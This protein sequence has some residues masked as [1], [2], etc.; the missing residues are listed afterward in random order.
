M[1]VVHSHAE[2]FFNKRHIKA[3]SVIG[4]DNFK[5]FNV[6][7]KVIKVL[8]IDI[9]MHRLT[10]IKSNRGYLVAPIFQSGSF[11]VNISDGIT[12]VRE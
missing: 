10:V 12:K 5:L 7:H 4:D 11:N 3:P 9:S 6:P 1:D 2:M 8:S